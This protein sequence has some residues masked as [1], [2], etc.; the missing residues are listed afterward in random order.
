MEAI[1]NPLLSSPTILKPTNPFSLSNVNKAPFLLSLTH[2]T[3]P[4]F[5]FSAILSTPP[6]RFTSSVTYATSDSQL[7]EGVET[8]TRE[9]VMQGGWQGAPPLVIVT[10]AKAAVFNVDEV[11]KIAILMEIVESLCRALWK[12]R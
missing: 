4:S 1:L 7:S 6:P 3:T 8:S 12:R 5:P 9:W 2:F 11:S 10:A